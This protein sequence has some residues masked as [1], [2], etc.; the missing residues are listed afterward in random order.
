MNTPEPA[1]P[2][3]FGFE[4]R[5]GQ[6][7]RFLRAGGGVEALEIVTA[8]EPRQRPDVQPIA[9]WDLAGTG[10]RER[11]TLYQ[12]DGYF[13]FWTTDV[14]GYRIEPA[15]GRIEIPES[16]D[17]ILR[18]Q[19]LWGLP[20]LLCLIYRDDFPLHAAAV[21]VG[22]G[23]VILAAPQRYGK[24]TLALAFHRR[25]HRVLSEDLCCC[26]LRPG[27]ELLP[28]P[29]LLRVRPDVYPG[30]PPPGTHILAARPDRVFLALDPDRR[31][32]SAPVPIKA[33]IFLRESPDEI[34]LEG[35]LPSVALAD[36]WSLNFRLQTA[37]GR[38]RSFRQL[39]RLVGGLPCWNLYRPLRLANLEPTVDVVAGHVRAL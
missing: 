14:G 27:A 35:A 1:P 36:L 13:E 8:P 4:V 37:E 15:R 38:A 25:G 28:G 21:E 30:S 22:D 39:T 20:T 16:K 31:G 10:Y 26:R 19:R 24:T 29:A 17:E 12:R 32:S 3:L 2:S 7:L 9:Q 11:G 34:R 5:S 18:E 23:A 33:I 6:A